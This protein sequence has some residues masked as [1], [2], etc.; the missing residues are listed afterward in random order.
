M[1]WRAWSVWGIVCYD[2]TPA[3]QIEISWVE[4]SISDCV[5]QINSLLSQYWRSLRLV[6]GCL[7]WSC[8]L[9]ETDPRCPGWSGGWCPCGHRGQGRRG[10]QVGPPPGGTRAQKR[11]WPRS[12]CCRCWPSWCRAGWRCPGLLC[13]L[14]C[15]QAQVE[16]GAGQRLEHWGGLCDS[17]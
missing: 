1:G 8:S 15:R 5:D 17:G 14:A 3:F 2:L 13:P 6:S 9:P 7:L 10:S 12:K 16:F 11:S 4:K